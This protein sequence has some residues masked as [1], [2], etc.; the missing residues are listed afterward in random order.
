MYF[1]SLN[2]HALILNHALSVRAREEGRGG[3]GA[4][5]LPQQP[6]RS[7][8]CCLS[9]L[10]VAQFQFQ[11]LQLVQRRA[12]CVALPECDKRVL[13]EALDN[14]VSKAFACAKKSAECSPRDLV[15]ETGLSWK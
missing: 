2:L 11:S 1:N 9:A 10:V 5:E 6:A 12:S 3:R 13:Y 7:R 8:L 4:S 14:E 15:P